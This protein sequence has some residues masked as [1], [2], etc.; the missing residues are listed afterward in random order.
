MT[1]FSLSLPILL[2]LLLL[3]Y[4]ENRVSFLGAAVEDETS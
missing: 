4:V 2:L 3:I 1:R